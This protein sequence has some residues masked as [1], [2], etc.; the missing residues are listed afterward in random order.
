MDLVDSLRRR[1]MR[2]GAVVLAGLATR[3]LGVRLGWTVGERGG[4]TF[5]GALLL[6]EQAG[7][8]FD[9]SFQFGDAALQRLTAGT[10][11]FIHAG[12]IANGPSRSCAFRKNMP[13]RW[14]TRYS[15]TSS[16]AAEMR[17]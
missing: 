13:P 11:G 12:K 15:N 16:L 4:L 5:A 3:L 8:A 6:F 9:L 1:S 2:L 17:G 14:L 10:S 7:E